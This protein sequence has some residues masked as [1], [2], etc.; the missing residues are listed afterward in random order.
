VSL[1]A[2]ID[3]V[4]NNATLAARFEVALPKAMTESLA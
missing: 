3:L 4:V 1:Q 2:N